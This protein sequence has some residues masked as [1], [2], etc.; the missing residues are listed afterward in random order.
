MHLKLTL[1][2]V[3]KFR[4]TVNYLKPSEHQWQHAFFINIVGNFFY[5]RNSIQEMST[6]CGFNKEKVSS[7]YFSNL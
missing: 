3:D 1:R 2:K 6:L 4:R 5:F 7:I